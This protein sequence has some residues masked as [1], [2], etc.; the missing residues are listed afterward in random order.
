MVGILMC[1]LVTGTLSRP[2]TA[3]VRVTPQD[4]ILVLSNIRPANSEG[5]TTSI[6]KQTP[7]LRFSSH[8]SSDLSAVPLLG[9]PTGEKTYA[10]DDELIHGTLA[11]EYCDDYH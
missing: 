7:W 9:L 1:V 3:V 2:S 8:P 5:D 6:L 4:N 11:R 10:T